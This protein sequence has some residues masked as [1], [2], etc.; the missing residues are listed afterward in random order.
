MHTA[1]RTLL[2]CAL[3]AAALPAATTALLSLDERHAVQDAF[4]EAVSTAAKNFRSRAGVRET[5]QRG[6][7]MRDAALE[8]TEALDDERRALRLQLAALRDRMETIRRAIGAD[9]LPSAAAALSP[10]LARSLRASRLRPSLA[11]EHAAIAGRLLRGD[12]VAAAF[13]STDIAFTLAGK[14]RDAIALLALS[15]AEYSFGDLA[16]EYETLLE[17]AAQARRDYAYGQGLI[18]RG[19]AQMQ[20]I[21]AVMRDVHDQVLALQGELARIDARLRSKAQRALIARGLLEPGEV[22]AA[23]HAAAERPALQWPVRGRLTA[24]FLE[25]SYQQ[26]F[27]VPHHGQDIAVNEGTPVHAAADG[28]VFVV[29]DGGDSGYTYVLIGHQAGLA[30]LYGH[31]RLVTVPAGA[32]VS[33][34]QVIGYSGGRPGTPGSGPLTSG[35]HLHFEVIENGVNVNPLGVLP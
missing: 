4:R 33:L 8:R 9:E 26:H 7:E 24:G 28:I 5:Q 22:R 20:S 6:Q 19:A 13:S 35:A 30:T 29:R 34:G 25:E 21:Q 11:T 18:D 3:C 12:G 15:L 10:D 14:R 32:E 31:L 2:A 17:Q 23:R 1:T 27:G 16:K